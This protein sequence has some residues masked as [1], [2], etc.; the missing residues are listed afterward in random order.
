MNDKKQFI[1]DM[2]SRLDDVSVEEII[3]SRI[4]LTQKGP[5]FYGLCPFHPDHSLGS[6]VVTPAKGMWKCFACGGNMA[7]NGINF[8][9]RYDNCNYLEAAFKIAAEKGLITYDEYQLYSRKR[10]HDDF[11]RQVENKYG[12]KKDRPYQK[13]ADQT[14]I[15]NV[16]QVLKDC[17]PLSEED[18]RA[19]RTERHLTDVR[20]QADYFTFPTYYRQKDRIINEIRRKYP[21]YTDDVLKYVPGFYIDKQK[22]K[23]TFAYMK[24]IGICIRHGN[25][26]QAIQIRRYTIKEGQRRYGWFTSGFAAD[27]PSKYDGGASCSSPHDIL[28]ADS[29]KKLLAITEGRFKA[30]VLYSAGNTVI[31]LQ[32]VTSQNNIE[33]DIQNVCSRQEIHSV[34]LFF[35]ADMLG[36]VE[37]FQQLSTLVKKINQSFPHLPVRIA[38]WRISYGKGIDDMIFSGNK[39][40]LQYYLPDTLFRIHADT[41]AS[42]LNRMGF[43]DL[44]GLC[45]SSKE[46]KKK[47]NEL[48]QEATEKIVC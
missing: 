12:A 47:F 13:K 38:V 18:L 42:V 43:S 40:Q 31:S 36:K 48:L 4:Q 33:K 1:E 30:E 35:D 39:N 3:G 6:F 10:Y 7:G 46:E 17:S 16:Y 22:N 2:F 14:V 44:T 25:Q 15:T 23:L 21:N 29:G 9:A 27:E 20:I 8:I 45:K 24:G 34:Y 28:Y 32:G 37:V 41:V 19:L 26:I 5:H 11:V